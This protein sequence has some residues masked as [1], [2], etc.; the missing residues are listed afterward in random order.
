M[1]HRRV[2]P[3][4][5]VDQPEPGMLDGDRLGPWFDLDGSELMPLGTEADEGAVE[6]VIGAFQLC[7]SLPK[8]DRTSVAIHLP[9]LTQLVHQDWERLG[10]RG[11]PVAGQGVPHRATTAAPPRSA[12]LPKSCGVRSSWSGSWPRLGRRVGC[13]VSGCPAQR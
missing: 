2:V 7:S 12:A 6:L 10:Q 3:I 5:A 1:T 8:I 4:D 9:L 13:W 11:R